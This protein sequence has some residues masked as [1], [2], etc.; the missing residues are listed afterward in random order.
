MYSELRENISAMWAQHMNDKL[1]V[2]TTDERIWV[3]RVSTAVVH[4]VCMYMIQK[5]L[6]PLRT[7]SITAVLR[8]QPASPPHPPFPP[9]AS[10]PE[11]PSDQTR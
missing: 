10:Q 8:R 1:Q 3:G 9:P 11:P 6:T 7:F 4:G 5:K 2:P